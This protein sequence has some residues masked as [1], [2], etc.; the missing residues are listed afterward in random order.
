MNE[1]NVRRLVV[2]CSQ[3]RRVGLF[4]R[5]TVCWS[6][7]WTPEASCPRKGGPRRIWAAVPVLFFATHISVRASLHLDQIR[8][9]HDWINEI[10]TVPIDDPA[11]PQPKEMAWEFPLDDV[12]CAA[13]CAWC[14]C[15]VSTL[16]TASGRSDQSHRLAPVSVTPFLCPIKPREGWDGQRGEAHVPERER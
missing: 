14:K 12:T 5:R 15:E 6:P 10:T 9:T 8:D 1:G 7:G 4:S 16:L 3:D 11:R 13:G 2:N